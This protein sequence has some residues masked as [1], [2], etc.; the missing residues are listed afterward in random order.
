MRKFKPSEL[1]NYEIDGVDR[2]D[3]PDFCDAFLSSATAKD[4]HELTE[5]E[6]DYVQ[7]TYPEWINELAFE[8]L[9]TN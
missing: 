8:S 1:D 6:L 5:E 4:G 9:I 3:Y 7:N 2:K